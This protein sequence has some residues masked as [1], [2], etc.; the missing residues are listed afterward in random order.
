MVY[1]LREGLVL[2]SRDHGQEQLARLSWAL[3]DLGFFLRAQAR[4][5]LPKS[6]MYSQQPL[7]NDFQYLP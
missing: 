6:I 2:G 7:T 1:G 3:E 4:R 5:Q